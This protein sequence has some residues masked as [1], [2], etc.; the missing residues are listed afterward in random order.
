MRQY[1]QRSFDLI[2]LGT[3]SNRVRDRVSAANHNKVSIY[4]NLRALI[5]V[6]QQQA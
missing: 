3:K 1:R 2:F 6:Q 5:E 4:E